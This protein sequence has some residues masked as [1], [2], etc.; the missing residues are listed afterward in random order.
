MRNRIGTILTVAMLCLAPTASWA[1]LAPYAQ[2][3][4]ALDQADPNS[5][6]NDGWLVFANVF[7][8][9][10]F[11]LYG[12]GPFLAPNGGP[13][14]SGID[15]GQGGPLQGNQQ[16]VVYS[17]Y[18]NGDHANGNII[19]ANVFQ[20]RIVGAADVGTTWLFEF[21][22]KRGNIAGSSTAL[23]FYKTLDPGAGYALTN[24]IA[25]D[26]TGISDS[27][28]SY[29]LSIFIDP[30]LE[31]QLL[32]FG[33]LNTATNYED[34]GIFYD[35]VVF[36]G[37]ATLCHVPPGNFSNRHTITV[38]LSAA[39]A[40]LDHGDELGACPSSALPS[41]NSPSAEGVNAP[42]PGDFHQNSHVAPRPTTLRRPVVDRS[43]R[44]PG[45]TRAQSD[46]E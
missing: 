24:F 28:S 22:A 33:F 20:E 26:M 17:D 46:G 10:G 14:F 6:A 5:L 9:G 35:N 1:D 4:E 31:G 2:D 11:Y 44:N 15:Q 12:Y 27:W 29:V 37:V 38:G 43:R 19:E 16:L 40:H 8:P 13:G 25:A 39:Q 23:A 3:F 41:S 34:S 21:D 30:S 18:N 45:G 32:Q 36:R 42:N 7:T